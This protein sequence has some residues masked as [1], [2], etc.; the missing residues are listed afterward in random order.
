MIRTLRQFCLNCYEHAPFI[1]LWSESFKV[2]GDGL[3]SLSLGE[4]ELPEGLFHYFIDLA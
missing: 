3:Q 2:K 4:R 1:I